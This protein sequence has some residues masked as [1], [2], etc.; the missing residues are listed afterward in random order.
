MSF[1]Q[2]RNIT[3]FANKL[4]FFC[5]ITDLANKSGAVFWSLA[6]GEKK[7]FHFRQKVKGLNSPNT[8]QKL[9]YSFLFYLNFNAVPW[10]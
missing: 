7:S 8:C 4:I 2:K 6:T 5:N 3:D 9:M 1:L 10:E